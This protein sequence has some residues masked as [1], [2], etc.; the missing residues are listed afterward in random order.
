L[1]ITDEERAVE[2]RG[3]DAHRKK[4]HFV[5]GDVSGGPDFLKLFIVGLKKVI[6]ESDYHDRS[7]RDVQERIEV[8]DLAHERDSQ[9][10][11]IKQL[12]DPAWEDI[13]ILIF[14]STKG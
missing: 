4:A 13:T 5:F 12:L 10:V 7:S 3:S 6:P 1:S 9:E 14:N 2:D 8:A 11:F